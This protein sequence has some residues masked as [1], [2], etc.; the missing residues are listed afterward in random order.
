MGIVDVV[1]TLT[2]VPSLLKLKKGLVPRPADTVDCYG[3]RVQANAERF[4]DRNAIVFEGKEINWRDFNAL[5]NQ[6]ANYFKAE[7]LQ[8]G[9]CVSVM[10]ENRIEYL[11][12]L[13]GLNKIGVTAGLINTNLHGRPLSH[14]VSVTHSKKCV[15]GSEVSEAISEISSELDLDEGEDFYVVPDGD[16]LNGCNWAKNLSEQAASVAADNPPDTQSTTL[17]ETCLYIFTSGTTGLPKAAVLSNRRYLTAADL[18]AQAGLKI[19]EKDRL[20]ICLPLYHATGLLLGVGSAFASGASMFIRRKFSASNFIPE[21]RDNNCTAFIYIGE[22][23]RY[24]TN[25]EA[26]PDDHK[27][28][29]RVMM[30]NGLRPDIWMSFKKRYGINRITEFYGASE[31]NVSF[32]N[33]LNKNCTV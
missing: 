14:C 31:G 27:N 10:M 13:I 32:A 23:C 7:G 29:I 17:G 22:L 28:P 12:L 19:T 11:A 25:S 21:V 26:K 20:Y 2:Q 15:F 8:R 1:S 6:Y 24:L 5:A 30:G 9:D 16:N 33:L 18:S 3:A 4:P